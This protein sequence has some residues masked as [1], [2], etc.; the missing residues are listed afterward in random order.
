MLICLLDIFHGHNN[1]ALAM[2]GQYGEIFSSLAV[3]PIL[4]TL[5]LNI[6]PYFPPAQCSCNNNK[7]YCIAEIFAGKNNWTSFC[8]LA[9]AYS[10]FI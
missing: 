8:T 3:E 9:K 5:E 2:V 1:I 4:P 6:F 10:N 7:L